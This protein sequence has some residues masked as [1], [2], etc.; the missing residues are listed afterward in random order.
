MV[1]ANNVNTPVVAGRSCTG[2]TMCCKL[3]G[4]KELEKPQQNWCSQCNIGVGCKIYDSKPD[5]CSTFFCGY[6]LNTS[7]GE[8]W[9]PSHCRMVLNYEAHA[10]RIVIHVDSSRLDAWRREPYYSEIKGW[11]A[12]AAENQG[13]VIVWQGLDAVAVLPDREIN[14]GHVR[15]DQLIITR[16][17]A[18]GV[19]FDVI[20]MERDDPRIAGI[21]QPT[22]DDPRTTSI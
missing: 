14:L 5:E 19:P 10:N 3:L 20:L 12:M 21:P 4:I 13:Q 17:T 15:S 9:R 11:A 2:C 18:A 1:S 8:A 22:E 6:L 7:I 16:A